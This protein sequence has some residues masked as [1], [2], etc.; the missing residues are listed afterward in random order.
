MLLLLDHSQR[1]AG[2][3]LRQ[4]MKIYKLVVG[5]RAASLLLSQDKASGNLGRTSQTELGL[6]HRG[7]RTQPW[8][9]LQA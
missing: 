4:V 1:E 8:L 7:K 3:A 6:S 5:G 9:I 2:T